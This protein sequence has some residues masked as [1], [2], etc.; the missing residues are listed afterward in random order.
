VAAVLVVEDD[1]DTCEAVSRYLQRGGHVV[2]RAASGRDALAALL[3]KTPDVVVLDVRLP[4]MDGVTFLDIIRSYLR[5]HR[6]PVILLTAYD[7]GDHIDR[8]Q[9]LGVKRI[10]LKANY[11]MADLLLAVNQYAREAKGGI[12]SAG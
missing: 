11:E 6:L 7:T 1:P 3:N 9:E 8:S 10:F 12:T 2:R 5:W 4:E